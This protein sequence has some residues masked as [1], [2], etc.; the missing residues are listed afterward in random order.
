MRLSSSARSSKGL[1]TSAWGP[2]VVSPSERDISCTGTHCSDRGEQ[3]R[4]A[5]RPA[6]DRHHA[7]AVFVRIGAGGRKFDGFLKHLRRAFHIDP[8]VDDADRAAEGA[9]PVAANAPAWPCR[10]PASD[11]RTCGTGP[12]ALSAHRSLTPLGKIDRDRQPPRRS[13]RSPRRA[14]KRIVQRPR[15]AGP[16]QRIDQDRGRVWPLRSPSI[17]PDQPARACFAASLDGSP[18]AATRTSRPRRRQRSL[19]RHSRR[20][21]YCPGPHSTSTGASDANR[22]VPLR[23]RPLPARSIRHGHTVAS[24]RYRALLRHTHFVRPLSTGFAGELAS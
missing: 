8:D 22:C 24:C 7:A 12:S 23:R 17:G 18:A 15:Q 10:A 4:T 5:H 20:R 13:T 3:R 9:L 1:W 19:P 2:P 14:D 6:D 11:G 16:E 21:R